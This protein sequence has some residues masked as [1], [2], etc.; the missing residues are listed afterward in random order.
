MQKKASIK[1]VAVA[2]RLNLHKIAILVKM[3]PAKMAGIVYVNP[4]EIKR[5]KRLDNDV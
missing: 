4:V 3:V 5:N 2:D 1:D